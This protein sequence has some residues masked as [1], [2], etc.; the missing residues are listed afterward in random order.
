MGFSL[1]EIRE[2]LDLYDL[3]DSRQTQRRVTIERCRQRIEA[4]RRAI[5]Y[6][7]DYVQR[8]ARRLARI[9]VMSSITAPNVRD[10]HGLGRNPSPPATGATPPE[11]M[12]RSAKHIEP[13]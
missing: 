5:N 3:G 12:P 11:T 6:R 13:G 10:L 1:G 4:L 8:Y 9:A 7:E 2:L